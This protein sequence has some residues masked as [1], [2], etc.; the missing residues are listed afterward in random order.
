MVIN[1][2]CYTG[3]TIFNSST[4]LDDTN[5]NNELYIQKK[6]T[7]SIYTTE[8]VSY[9]GEETRAVLLP[10]RLTDDNNGC[11]WRRRTA[12]RLKGLL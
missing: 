6:E 10:A 7:N 1:Q 9:K 11:A 8:L 12:L 3:N 4:K 5:M 2:L